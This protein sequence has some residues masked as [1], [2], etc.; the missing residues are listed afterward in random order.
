MHKHSGFIYI[1]AIYWLLYWC[2]FESQLIVT[3]YMSNPSLR[4]CERVLIQTHKNADIQKLCAGLKRDPFKPAFIF[5]RA[6]EILCSTICF[7]FFGQ[8]CTQRL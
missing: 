2:L 6:S 8:R 5:L 3:Q 7:A 1:I 4:Q